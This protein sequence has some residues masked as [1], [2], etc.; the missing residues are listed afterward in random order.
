[1][2]RIHS[3]VP[4][5]IVTLVA[6][7]MGGV[8]LHFLHA[9]ESQI[10]RLS[11]APSQIDDAGRL[12]PLAEL[13]EQLRSSW[14]QTMVIRSSV[15]A[16]AKDENWL[17]GDTLA[18]VEVPVSYRYGVDLTKLKNSSFSYTPK[19]KMFTIEIPKPTR[20]TEILGG[21]PIREDVE[22]GWLRFKK[23]S[24]N[25]QLLVAYKKVQEH[26]QSAALPFEKQQEVE[27]ESLER[28]KELVEKI[29]GTESRVDVRYDE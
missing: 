18:T 9:Q 5:A 3:V 17:R 24:G 7:A 12:R 28:V 23:L 21:E 25:Q 16:E 2:K 14:L 27:T 13:A 19:G 26:A 6:L 15:V 4:I 11:D 1:M 22:V 10:L 29:V 20:I 8:L